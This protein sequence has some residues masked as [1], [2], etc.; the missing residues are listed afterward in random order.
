MKKLYSVLP[1]VVFVVFLAVMTLLLFLLPHK[2]YSENEKRNLADLPEVSV[3][4]IM[5]GSFQ[6]DLETFTAAEYWPYPTYAD[7]L[8]SV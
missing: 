6:E 1:A 3:Q 5:D 4:A 8:F 7:I 2:D